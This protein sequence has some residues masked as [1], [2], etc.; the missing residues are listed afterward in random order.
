MWQSESNLVHHKL[1]QPFWKL[2]GSIQGSMEL[3]LCYK[4]DLEVGILEFV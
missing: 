4:K 1:T 3:N 2:I